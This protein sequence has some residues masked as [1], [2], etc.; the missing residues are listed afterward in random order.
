MTKNEKIYLFKGNG[1]LIRETLEQDIVDWYKWFNDPDITGYLFHGF[2]PNTI[3]EQKLFREKHLNGKNGKIIFSI[4]E[5]KT[6][7]LI[8]TCSINVDFMNPSK[9]AEISMVI[10]SKKFHSGPLYFSINKWMIN[11]CFQQLNLNSIFAVTSEDHAVVRLTIERIG[12]KKVG[13]LRSTLF[14]DGKYLNSIYYDLLKSD[15]LKNK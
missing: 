12:F 13:K 1:F 11:H 3:E 10:G 15:W 4:E 9:R 6:N 5:D 7:K 14:K 2:K 8:G